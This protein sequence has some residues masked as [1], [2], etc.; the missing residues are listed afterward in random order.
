MMQFKTLYSAFQMETAN[1]M[2]N[3]TY[4]QYIQLLVHYSYVRI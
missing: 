3:A 1:P 2:K 4:E